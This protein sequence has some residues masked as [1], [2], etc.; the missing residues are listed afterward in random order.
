MASR[1]FGVLLCLLT[2]WIP[3]DHRYDKWARHA[4]L[5]WIPERLTIPPWF[6]KRL[7][8]Y[9]SDLLVLALFAMLLFAFRLS[10]WK[11]LRSHY[12]PWMIAFIL[13][14]LASII[15]SPLYS[16][17]IIYTRLL[18]LVTPV[19]LFIAVSH[20]GAE[21]SLH[22]LGCFLVGGLFQA[23]LGLYQYFAQAPLGLSSLGELKNLQFA[24][25]IPS[26]NGA[27][28]LLDYVFGS[29]LEISTL[30]RASGTFNHANPLGLFLLLALFS[31]FA[32]YSEPKAK[33]I[34]LAV[35]MVLL[36]AALIVTYSRSALFGAL[37][38]TSIFVWKAKPPRSLLWVMAIPFVLC[39][40]LFGEQIALR[41]GII[42]TSLSK[43][44]DQVRLA[45]NS[46]ALS[47]IRQHPMLGVG[48][49]QFTYA[50]EY[51]DFS[52]REAITMVHNSPLLIAAESGLFALLCIGGFILSILRKGWRQ[53]ASPPAVVALSTIVAFC[54]IANCDFY[55]YYFQ[56]AKISLFLWIGLLIALLEKQSAL[57]RSDLLLQNNADLLLSS[58]SGEQPSR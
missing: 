31:A 6:E 43:A 57:N 11:I 3:F 33:R 17:P 7:Y 48:Y 44:S 35:T 42:P 45:Q 30:Y 46:V 51:N 13:I 41:G 23:G 38:G 47:M 18:Q 56:Q 36:I 37:L 15:A 58:V 39:L 20:K 26:P 14:C 5:L 54:W 53:A 12:A 24:G 19:L 22:I 21:W 10:I 16:Y 1:I 4:S 34:P 52:A 50:P 40:I 49:Q 28:W 29:Q 9:S 2:L 32:L 55:P 27:R 25:Q 8:F